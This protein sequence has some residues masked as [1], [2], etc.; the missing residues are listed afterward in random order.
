MN[1]RCWGK[2][3][4]SP[5]LKYQPLFDFAL[6]FFVHFFDALKPPMQSEPRQRGSSAGDGPALVRSYKDWKGS[7]VSLT[8]TWVVVCFSLCWTWTQSLVW[9]SL[10]LVDCGSWVLPSCFKGSSFMSLVE[11]IHRIE[12]CGCDCLISLMIELNSI[13]NEVEQFCV[14]L[15]I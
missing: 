2:V 1:E 6:Y 3:S 4:S 12:D 14:H 13:R 11:G 10:T 15:W 7:N 5:P 9:F 8:L